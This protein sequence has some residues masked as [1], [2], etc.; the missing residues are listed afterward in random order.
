MSP[1]LL[2]SLPAILFGLTVHEYAHGYVAYK[3][4]DPTA[5]FSGRLT[6]NPL[7]HLDPIGI[8]SAIL[9]RIGWAKPVPI[10]PLNFRNMRRDI[11]LTSLAGPGS[12]FIV[13]FLSGL[14][15]RFFTPISPF[16]SQLF[17]SFVIYNLIFA[18][19]NLIPIPPLDG[20]KIISYILPQKAVFYYMELERYGFFILLFIIVIGNL[21][22][23]S[24]LFW[25]MNPFLNF[26]YRLFVG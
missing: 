12:N 17:D 21:L 15:V 7:S 3:L 16:F 9:F 25:I 18:F 26:F 5:K 22:G 10:D 23:F 13:A 2:L 19:F 20:S 6:F 11:L 24:L 4:G 8:F 1:S 14:L